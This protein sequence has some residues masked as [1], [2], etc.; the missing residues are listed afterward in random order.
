MRMRSECTWVA[1]RFQRAERGSWRNFQLFQFRRWIFNNEKQKQKR[2]PRRLIRFWIHQRFIS[3]PLRPKFFP[4][5]FAFRNGG[6]W[7][8]SWSSS[9]HFKVSRESALKGVPP[10]RLHSP[11]RPALPLALIIHNLPICISIGED[12]SSVF[13]CFLIASLCCR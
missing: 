2:G 11:F 12:A 10:R 4:L 3:F 13:N 6:A 5:F 9:G 1:K 8:Y 7:I